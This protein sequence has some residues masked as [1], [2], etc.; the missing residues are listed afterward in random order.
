MCG[1]V[2]A[3]TSMG[4][5]ALSLALNSIAHRGPD[6]QRLL[7]SGQMSFGFARLA[8]LELEAGSQPHVLFD[9]ELVTMFNGEIYNYQEIRQQLQ[10]EGVLFSGTSEVEVISR[11]FCHWG[12]S[13]PNR[14]RGMFA[15]SIWDKKHKILYLVRDPIGKKPLYWYGKDD[16]FAFSSEIKA[17]WNLLPEKNLYI[18]KKSVASFLIS[19]SVPTPLSIDFRIKKVSAGA[20]LKWENGKITEKIYWP[21]KT[22]FTPS[23]SKNVSDEFFNKLNTS[24]ERRLLSEVP[25]GVFLSSG[26]DSSVVAS[27]ISK[28]TSKQIQSFTLKFSGSYDESKAAEKL[29]S[30]YK[31]EHSTV[32]ATDEALAEIW[33]QA[34]NTIDEPLSDPAI[35]P[36]MLLSRAAKESVKVAIT[37]DGGDE[38]F[39]GYPHLKLHK[40]KLLVNPMLA[41]AMKK[42][43]NKWPDNGRYFGTGF[44]LQRLARGLGQ[45]KTPL[46]DLAW[47]GSFR[48]YE[49]DQI[50]A[51][52]KFSSLHFPTLLDNL[53]SDFENSPIFSDDEDKMS[54]WY[55][56]TYLLDTVLVKVDRGSMAF[57]VE[58]RSPLLD[59]D[60]VEFILAARNSGALKRYPGKKLLKESLHQNGYP[61]PTKSGKHG[62]GVPVIRLF[63]T[64]LRSEF[65]KLT[66]PNLIVSQGIFNVESVLNLKTELFRGRKEV[67]KEAW[68]VFSF[69]AWLRNF[70]KQ[71][72]IIKVL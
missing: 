7:E 29:A 40:N 42:I 52:D 18:D 8:I 50:L 57:G 6:D 45:K 35:L 55:L 37:G 41:P 17:I 9:H 53:S 4:R 67:R 15:I 72:M 5:E 61:Y 26:L 30:S 69:Q 46:R 38:L 39:L 56:R 36:M 66:D 25:V 65:E 60:L 1:I 16:L 34:V 70:T 58:C 68:A 13:F 63:N 14:L 24:V 3:S 49:V 2:G 10:L 54:W 64:V 11:A 43:L 71:G 51:S 44:R 27:T 47:R 23:K 32:H 19:D 62:M 59:V 12:E 21:T 20:M 31:F 48:W 33:Y 22:S 28:R